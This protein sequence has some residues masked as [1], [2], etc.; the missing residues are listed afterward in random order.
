MTAFRRQKLFKSNYNCYYYYQGSNC[1]MASCLLF[2]NRNK[3][4]KD[5]FDNCGLRVIYGMRTNLPLKYR[6]DKQVKSFAKKSNFMPK[7]EKFTIRM[8]V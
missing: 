4:R 6:D 3:N 7:W 8:H 1:L 2:M 5:L